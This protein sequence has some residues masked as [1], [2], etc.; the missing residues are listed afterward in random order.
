MKDYLYYLVDERMDSEE[1]SSVKEVLCN[2]GA[3][4]ISILPSKEAIQKGLKRVKGKRK[5]ALIVGNTIESAEAAK[6]TNTDFCAIL[7][8]TTPQEAFSSYP[9]RQLL[10]DIK[11]LP[12]LGQP[13]PYKKLS[14]IDWQIQKYRRWVHF[15]QI[16]GRSHRSK[17]NVKEFVCQNCGEIYTGNYCP[18]C[19]QK[20]NVKRYE[21]KN[22]F[23]EFV[24]EAID[25]EHG[26]MRS[27]ME[28][29]WRPGYMMRDY[30]NGH[31]K[32]YN[33]PF[34][35]IFLLATV[36]LIAAHLLDPASFGNKKQD[37]RL[38]D[39]PT[40][41][42]QLSADSSN[43]EIAPYLNQITTL[44]KEAII[45]KR[46][47]DANLAVQAADS[48][49]KRQHSSIFMSSE[50]SLLIMRQVMAS[51]NKADS[52]KLSDVLKENVKEYD[53][54]W[55]G[56]AQL[57]ASNAETVEKFE[58][59]YYHE[60]T[61]LYSMMEMIKDF[62]DMNKAVTI[63]LLIPVMVY[64]ARRSF[65]TTLVGMKLNL[66]EYIVVFTHF[67]AQLMWLQ[68][69]TLLTSRQADFSPFV[70]MG[71]GIMLLTWDMKQLFNLSWKDSLKRTII[72]M[73]GNAFIFGLILTAFLSILS[74]MLMW[75]LYQIT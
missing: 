75:V 29:F 12:L 38:E 61:L 50:D 60:G 20:H 65:R 6:R 72:Y 5:F 48:I 13:Y 10:T 73:Y 4:V 46:N 30:L 3:K 35:A 34:N 43:K 36:Y 11:L 62:F 33:K 64:C 24:T 45:I 18:V 63:I 66:A 26:F 47:N 7:D 71:T 23:K 51:I 19:G 15:K 9:Y 41:S 52:V 16:R 28:L 74:S 27:F 37:T 2:K 31:R 56:F 69:F 57:A 1:L 39:I 70:D 67:G 68:L 17:P 58:E 21:L 54:F 42:L 40:I 25:L 8:G 49:L 53:G 32:S 59:K 44:S 55:G 22:I 14:G